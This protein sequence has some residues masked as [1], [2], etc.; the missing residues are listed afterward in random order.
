MHFTFILLRV[1]AFN[2]MQ[3]FHSLHTPHIT[4]IRVYENKLKREMQKYFG[5][6]NFRA[7]ECIIHIICELAKFSFVCAV[8]VW[9][10]CSFRQMQRTCFRILFIV[11]GRRLAS[12]YGIDLME[13]KMITETL[14]GVYGRPNRVNDESI[15]GTMNAWTKLVG[16]WECVIYQ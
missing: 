7:Y 2:K 4:Q 13:K 3:T 1:V 8:S 5:H 16:D 14:N 9:R 10:A 6:T 11:Y 15:N 12:N